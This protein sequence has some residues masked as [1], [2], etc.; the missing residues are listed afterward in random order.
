MELEFPL[1]VEV[2]VGVAA[3]PPEAAE[4]VP[5]APPESAD[6]IAVLLSRGLPEPPCLYKHSQFSFNEKE[7]D[8]LRDLSATINSNLFILIHR[9]CFIYQP[10]S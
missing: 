1:E 2:E 3:F 8:S 6:W 4:L 10:S 5:L 7:N 9:A